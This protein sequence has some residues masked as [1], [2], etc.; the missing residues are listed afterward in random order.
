MKSGKMIPMSVPAIGQQQ[1]D[2]RQAVPR[3]CECGSELFDKAVKVGMVS[4]MAVGNRTGMDIVAETNVYV[5]R[6]CEKILDV[7]A[8]EKAGQPE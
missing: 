3:Q 5:C 4:R 8:V 1:F 7:F 2:I 6:D